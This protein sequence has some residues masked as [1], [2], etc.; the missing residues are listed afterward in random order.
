M[1]VEDKEIIKYN[2]KEKLIFS[3]R[4]FKRISNGG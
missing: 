4:K 1:I 3:Y 2:L